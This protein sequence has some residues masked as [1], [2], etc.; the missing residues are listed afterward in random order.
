M[1]L[2]PALLCLLLAWPA[3]A[4]PALFVARGPGITAYLLGSLHALKPGT[5][6]ES[7]S[8]HR[9][10]DSAGECW[11]ELVLSDDPVP[12]TTPILAHAFDPA[13]RLSTLLTPADQ[14]V[15]ERQV[16]RLHVPGGMT[17]VNAMRPWWR[18]AICRAH[19][20]PGF[21]AGRA[22]TGRRVAPDAQSGLGG[23]AD[24]A[25]EQRQDDPGDGGYQAPGGGGQSS[26]P[27]DRAPLDGGV[28]ALK[29]LTA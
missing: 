2:W 21:S 27:V 6:W 16:A 7:A 29:D 23:A 19:D 12:V 4:E 22:R 26:G 15:L 20:E 13:H 25:G 8:I 5:V 28:G 14:A 11:F 1:R 24:D 9:A 18:L 10:F 17:R 3:W